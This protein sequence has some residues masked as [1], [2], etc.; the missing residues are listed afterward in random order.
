LIE[1]A[2]RH[3]CTAVGIEIKRELCEL[4][5]ER[6]RQAEVHK[7]VTIREEDLF[8]SKF[9]DATVVAIYLFPGLLERLKPIFEQL[10]PGTRIVSHQFAIPGA[11]PDATETV[12]SSET[13][14]AHRIYLWTTPLKTA[15]LK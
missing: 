8:E 7:L 4:S 12:S 10:K 3:G 14:D 1:A 5:R 11:T 6:A 13:G 2:K 9:D 15:P